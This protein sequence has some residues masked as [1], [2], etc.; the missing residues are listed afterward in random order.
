MK[1][2]IKLKNLSSLSLYFNPLSLYVGTYRELKDEALIELSKGI[3]ELKTL[4]SLC[5]DF[6]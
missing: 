5:L 4:S 1:G 3:K 2:L 6:G